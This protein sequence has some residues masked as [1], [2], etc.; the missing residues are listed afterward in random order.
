MKGYVEIFSREVFIKSVVDAYPKSLFDEASSITRHPLKIALDN[1]FS[2]EIITYMIQKCPKILDIPINSDQWLPI[3]YACTQKVDSVVIN[4]MLSLFP[5]HHSIDTKDGKNP[6]KLALESSVKFKENYAIVVALNEFSH[7]L[8]KSGIQKMPNE[9]NN[10]KSCISE[11]D[12]KLK[13]VQKINSKQRGESE[14]KKRKLAES[15]VIGLSPE[16][17]HQAQSKEFKPPDEQFNH[18]HKS[19]EKEMSKINDELKAIENENEQQLVLLQTKTRGWFETY[20]Y[21]IVIETLI[22]LVIL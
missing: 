20:Y 18:I 6:L 19:M 12:K 11:P 14:N 17:D 4:T 7:S 22:L 15:K 2:S 1:D 3:H 21:S 10:A 9:T 8:V 5:H 13:K 16:D